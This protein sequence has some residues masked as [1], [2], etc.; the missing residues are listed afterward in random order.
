MTHRAHNFSQLQ[1]EKKLQGAS[2]IIVFINDTLRKVKKEQP[3][4]I[5]QFTE[6]ILSSM[7]ITQLQIVINEV[8]TFI[9]MLNEALVKNL[10]ERDELL[11]KRDAMLI[12]IERFSREKKMLERECY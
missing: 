10:V 11:S 7:N 1:H 5:T 4:L 3:Q 2:Q 8:H 9:E 6:R 12:T